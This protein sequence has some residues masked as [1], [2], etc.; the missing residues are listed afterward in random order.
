M[1]LRYPQFEYLTS[2]NPTS[3]LSWRKLAPCSW[4]KI[5]SSQGGKLILD[6]NLIQLSVVNI[7]CHATILFLNEHVGSP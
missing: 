3:N 5:P 6:G 7:L 2:D 4:S 1:S